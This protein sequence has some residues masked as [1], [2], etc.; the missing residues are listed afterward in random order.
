MAKPRNFPVPRNAFTILVIVLIAGFICTLGAR[1]NVQPYYYG[2]NL[3]VAEFGNNVPGTYGVDYVFPSVASLDYYKNKGMRVIRLPFLWERLQTSLNG[4]LDPAN[5]AR[6]DSIVAGAA[7]R[8]MFVLLDAHNYARYNGNIIG[9][10]QVPA[11]AFGDFWKKMA[12]HFKNKAGVYAYDLSNEPHDM[13]A[14]SWFTDAQ[15]AIDSIRTVD[16]T[17]MI[18]VEGNSWASG[19]NWPTASDALKSLTD[20]ANNLMFEAHVYFDNNASGTYGQSYQNDGANPQ[21]GVTRVSHFISWCETNNKRGFIG[22]FGIPGND[23]NW[24]TVLDNFLSYCDQHHVGGTYWAGGPWWGSYPLSVE[25]A[26][27]VDKSQMSILSKYTGTTTQT[28][29]TMAEKQHTAQPA[30]LFSIIHSARV[31]PMLHSQGGKYYSLDGRA[32]SSAASIK[33]K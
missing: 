27:N 3:A 5:L 22:E 7:A 10:S 23:A 11:A 32:A 19:D 13:G 8:N 15:V 28:V 24:A 9:S 2:V 25:P 1:V 33:T 30:A 4:Q 17:T 21:I 14:Y 20:Q 26:G 18:M 29:F 6:M 31:G 12:A 16:G